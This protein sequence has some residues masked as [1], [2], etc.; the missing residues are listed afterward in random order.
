MPRVT[1]RD[2]SRTYQILIA[3]GWLGVPVGLVAGIIPGIIWGLI[4]ALLTWN[5][6][7]RSSDRALGGRLPG[8]ASR[9]PWERRK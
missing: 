9:W 4:M 1:P 5:S 6:V 8:S 3:L 7:Y 2:A